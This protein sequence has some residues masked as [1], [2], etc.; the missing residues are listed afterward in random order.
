MKKHKGL[1]DYRDRAAYCR[2]WRKLTRHNPNKA[3]TAKRNE[4]YRKPESAVG[5]F[6]GLGKYVEWLSFDDCG[7]MTERVGI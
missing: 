2:A 7:A 5:R 3:R 1:P 4:G 6:G